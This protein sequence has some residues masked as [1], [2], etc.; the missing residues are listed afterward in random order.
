[1]IGLFQGNIYLEKLINLIF[2][3]NNEESNINQKKFTKLR[4]KFIEEKEIIKKLIEDKK[5]IK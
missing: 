1:M 3:F 2:I 4:N 5:Q